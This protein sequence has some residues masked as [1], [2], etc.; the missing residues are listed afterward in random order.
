LIIYSLKRLN[1]SGKNE[2]NPVNISIII[3]ARNE[4]ENIDRLI[5]SMKS[6]SYPVELFE[7]IIVDDNSSD[8]TFNKLK[9]KTESIKNF[10]VL[11]LRSIG[12][13]GKREALNFGFSKSNYPYILI[14]DADCTPQ[15]KWLE[16]FSK[17]FQWDYDLLFGIAPFYQRNNFVNK[18]ACFENLRGSILSFSMAFLGLP[19]TAAAR[20]FGFS[21]KAFESL[22]RYSRTTDT[23]SGDD[24]LLLREAVKNKMKIG[25]VNETD[26]FVYSETKKTFKEYFRQRARHTQT[27]FHYLK[28]H[29]VILGFWHSLNLAFL[30][31]P[32][33]I[34][35]NPL[36]GILLPSKL[37]IDYIAV[38]SNQKKF[39]Y[40]FSAV[41]IIYLQIFYEIFL[42]I[43]FFNARFSEIRWK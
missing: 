34:L 35:L 42:I 40:K 25:F 26:S 33:L 6:L 8:E 14:T 21:K 36:F 9:T 13:T 1:G 23:I 43:H 12:K 18:I 24:D 31:S 20:N 3:A 30:F 15:K 19:Y 28:R 11:E 39:G 16:C 10:S 2:N 29:Q 41:E 17:K 38:K 37:I 32:L 27:S 4:T 22:G 5:D 7:V